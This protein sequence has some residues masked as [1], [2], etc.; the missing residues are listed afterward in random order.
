MSISALYLKPDDLVIPLHP[1]SKLCYY[2]QW[3]LGCCER[4]VLDVHLVCKSTV[5]QY[6]N[7][8]KVINYFRCLD[9][10]GDYYP[11]VT[12]LDSNADINTP[13]LISFRRSKRF[14]INCALI[15]INP[16]QHIYMAVDKW[17]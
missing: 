3:T 13:I 7:K 5:G 9:N 15:R 16:P 14:D 1:D 10:G 6:M 4:M 11:V 12:L 8:M 2:H 17:L